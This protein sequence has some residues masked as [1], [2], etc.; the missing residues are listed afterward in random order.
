MLLHDIL[1]IFYR[2]PAV[3]PNVPG[4][5]RV[6]CRITSSNSPLLADACSPGNSAFYKECLIS[7][8]FAGRHFDGGLGGSLTEGICA[9]GLGRQLLGLDGDAL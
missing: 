2:K 7:F 9:N 8:P 1:A 5:Q 4:S 3:M 6:F